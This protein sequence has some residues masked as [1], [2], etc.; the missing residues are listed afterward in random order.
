V[1]FE[2][3]E[4]TAVLTEGYFVNLPNFAYQTQSYAFLP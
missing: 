4:A 2:S 3:P 1:Y